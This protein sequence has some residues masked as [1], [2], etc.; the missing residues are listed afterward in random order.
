MFANEPALALPLTSAC[1][2]VHQTP[3]FC[4]SLLTARNLSRALA[5]AL[6][7]CVYRPGFPWTEQRGGRGGGL[8]SVFLGLKF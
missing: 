1:R 7:L 6:P 4:L 2:V 5:W 3:G 8:A